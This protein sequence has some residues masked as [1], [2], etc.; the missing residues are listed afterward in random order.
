MTL[1][2]KEK[3]WTHTLYEVST[4]TAGAAYQVKA[5]LVANGWTVTLS[6]ASTQN[7]GTASAADWWLSAADVVIGQA[8]IVLKSPHAAPWYMMMKPATAG[9]GTVKVATV[10][11]TGGSGATAATSTTQSTLS[12]MNPG[13][14]TGGYQMWGSGGEVNRNWKFHVLQTTDVSNKEFRIIGCASGVTRMLFMCGEMADNRGAANPNFICWMGNTSTSYNEVD[15]IAYGNILPS[16]GNN[17][18]NVGVPATGAPAVSCEG[19]GFLTYSSALDA[20][21]PHGLRL[22]TQDAVTGGDYFG[23]IGL[24]DGYFG[25]RRGRIVDVYWGTVTI[26][27]GFTYPNDGSRQWIKLGAMIFPCDGT[28]WLLT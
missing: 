11:F 7:G 8:W 21:T 26:P 13:D 19:Y 9:A 14:S 6:R 28:Q 5:I 22:T 18:Y 10:A 12:C 23:S 15:A 16:G 24:F 3:T 4:G 20:N 25:G 17:F 2:V 27:T 1:P